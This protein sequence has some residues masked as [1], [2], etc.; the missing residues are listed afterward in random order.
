MSLILWTT[1]ATPDQWN[2]PNNPFLPPPDCT[3][4]PRTASYT[5]LAR[6]CTP[7]PP[8]NWLF[9]GDTT[10]THM[11]L[12]TVDCA[13]PAPIPTPSAPLVRFKLGLGTACPVPDP[14]YIFSERNLLP[15]CNL[16]LSNTFAWNPRYVWGT[17]RWL[18]YNSI[19]VQVSPF[20]YNLQLYYTGSCTGS[21]NATFDN[22]PL[23]GPLDSTCTPNIIG[24]PSVMRSWLTPT[25]VTYPTRTAS[26]PSPSPNSVQPAPTAVASP[27]AIA[28][29]SVGI[30]FAIVSCCAMG[31][32]YYRLTS[33]LNANAAPRAV[34]EWASKTINPAAAA[35]IN[36]A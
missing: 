22:I 29:G 9:V 35:G 2:F 7:I 18:D 8:T 34:T 30:A 27:T 4:S 15:G 21:P 32:M 17:R 3:S 20:G 12:T 6:V 23:G 26:S 10:N 16:N 5:L 1:P 13:S 31:V 11:M 36:S 24:F 33:L 28:L 25:T 14:T 19:N